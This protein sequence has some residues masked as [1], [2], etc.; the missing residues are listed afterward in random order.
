MPIFEYICQEC[1]HRFETIVRGSAAPAC[2][3]CKATRLEKQWSAFAV[4]AT[5]VPSSSPAPCGTCG[6]PRGP[7]ACVMN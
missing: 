1:N 5:G 3:V 6:D 2:P 7:G 4:G